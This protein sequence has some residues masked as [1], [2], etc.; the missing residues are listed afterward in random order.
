MTLRHR[1]TLWHW[2]S[3]D[4]P[5][6]RPKHRGS[7]TVPRSW[8]DADASGLRDGACI[9]N[10]G[11]DTGAHPTLSARGELAGSFRL[12][13]LYGPLAGH[14]LSSYGILRTYTTNPAV[15]RLS[16]PGGPAAAPTIAG[17]SGARQKRAWPLLVQSGLRREDRRMPACQCQLCP[18]SPFGWSF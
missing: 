10:E 4:R 6:G 5:W 3:A 16:G 7:G 11:E 12:Q 9:E 2:L 14:D 15:P 13:G 8:H 17:H 1:T 18:E